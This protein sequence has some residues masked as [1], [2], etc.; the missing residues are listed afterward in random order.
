VVSS[1]RDFVMKMTI[2][3]LIHVIREIRAL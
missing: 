2:L 3:N 1:F